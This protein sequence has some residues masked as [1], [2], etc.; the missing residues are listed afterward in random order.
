MASDPLSLR[1]AGYSPGVLRQRPVP[2]PFSFCCPACAAG[3]LRFYPWRSQPANAQ[4]LVA[5]CRSCSWLGTVAF[6]QGP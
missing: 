1:L 3:G 5:R 4:L 2:Q 6:S